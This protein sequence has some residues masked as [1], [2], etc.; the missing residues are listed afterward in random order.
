MSEGST[1]PAR[2]SVPRGRHRL[3][4]AG[5]ALGVVLGMGTLL[6]GPAVRERWALLDDA[7]SPGGPEAAP[8]E[9]RSETVRLAFL[10]PDGRTL[11]EE[12]RELTLQSSAPAAARAI[13]EA[14]RTGSRQGRRAVLPPAVQ[15]RHVFV[16][17]RGVAY[18]DLSPEVLQPS[19]A[20]GGSAGA[21]P[22]G[23]EG[24][25]RPG[26]A[27]A[28]HPIVLAAEAIAA[29]LGM[30]IQEIAQV[31]VL[32]EG[33]EVPLV[34][35]GVDLRRPLPASLPIRPPGTPR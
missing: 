20:P 29:T 30:N 11:E 22:G 25:Q 32:V 21:P 3:V 6:W 17:K 15:V 16:D 19:G 2:V 24:A 26:E 1:S 14:L 18:V 7:Q 10:G 33:R 31:Q 34:T 9:A 8:A 12:P 13:L 23:A 4:A 27:E 28:W 5:A 35:D